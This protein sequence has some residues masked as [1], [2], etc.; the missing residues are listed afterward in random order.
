M[1]EVA[2][3]GVTKRFG[4]TVAVD[5]IDFRVPE[6]A[7]LTLLGPS[8]CGKTTTLRMVAGLEHPT[9]GEIFIGGDVVSG[10]GRFAPPERRNIGM[11][12][13]SYAVWPHLTVYANVA[14]P[15]DVRRRSRSEIRRDVMDALRMVRLEPYVDRFPFQL[16]GGQQQRVALARALVFRPRL[17]LLD[18]P[19]SN[20]D[21]R[22]REEM[23]LEIRELQQRLGLTTLYVTHDQQE[24]LGMSDL[25]AVMN[26]GRI[27]Q[28][29]PPN[30][31]HDYPT[32]RFVADFVGWKNTLPAVV[33]D[34]GAV[35]LGGY[36][37]Q[38]R[39]PPGLSTGTSVH[40]CVRPED[41][42]VTHESTGAASNVLPARV[43]SRVYTGRYSLCEL[44]MGPV[45]LLAQ[46]PSAADFWPNAAVNVHL[47][48]DK[49]RVLV[50]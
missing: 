8:G 31:I 36:P 20:L 43:K 44:I 34:P 26:V 13:Q 39:V 38:C 33:V 9:Q 48:P 21:A 28:M 25:V 42:S 19:L 49:L 32:S 5:G 11:V 15:L 17:L 37:I 6:G 3:A 24:A 35:Q 14:F 46:V 47:G 12:F 10:N 41:V 30:E 1:A 22:L 29:G 23:R 27:V 4:Q 2:L 18:E 45:T 40:V 16:S 7:A 50:E